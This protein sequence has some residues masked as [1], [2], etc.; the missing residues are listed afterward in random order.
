MKALKKVQKEFEGA[1]KEADL[2]SEDDV[3]NLLKENKRS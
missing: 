3:E 1:A 2:K